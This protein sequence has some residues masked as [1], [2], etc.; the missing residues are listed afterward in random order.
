MRNKKSRN[1]TQIDKMLEI[2]KEVCSKVPKVIITAN[3]PSKKAFTNSPIGSFSFLS[4][5]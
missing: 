5:M 3:I 1:Y 4:D 2:P